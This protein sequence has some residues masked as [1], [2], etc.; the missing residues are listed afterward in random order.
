MKVQP[1]ESSSYA[2]RRNFRERVSK[3]R[4]LGRALL[5]L[6]HYLE[7]EMLPPTKT[8]WQ[9]RHRTAAHSSWLWLERLCR[10]GW[11]WLILLPQHPEYWDCWCAPGT[12]SSLT[13]FHDQTWALS[14][15][16]LISHVQYS[17]IWKK[18]KVLTTSRQG[19]FNLYL[20]TGSSRKSSKYFTV[21]CWVVS[22]FRTVLAVGREL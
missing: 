16:Y 12:T 20:K 15:R 18:D 2:G 1:Q 8:R 19:I 7:R 14:P 21:G 4:V 13:N 5:G 22:W 10:P 3:S 11:H 9:I 6:S 17:K